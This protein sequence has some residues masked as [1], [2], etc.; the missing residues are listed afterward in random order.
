[1]KFA[2]ILV[3]VMLESHINGMEFGVANNNFGSGS[4]KIWSDNSK[5][6]SGIGNYVSDIKSKKNG[7]IKL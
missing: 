2:P 3:F 6:Q 4:S 5:I 1:M 7:G